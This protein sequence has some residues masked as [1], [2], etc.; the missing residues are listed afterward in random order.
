MQNM[1]N[2]KNA[3][4]EVEQNANKRAEAAEIQLETRFEETETQKLNSLG[5]LSS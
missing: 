5:L 1:V 2:Q 3:T 4:E